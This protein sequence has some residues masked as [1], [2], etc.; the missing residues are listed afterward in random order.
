MVAQEVEALLNKV[1]ELHW[2]Y[3]QGLVAV[4][5]VL[6]L[7]LQSWDG[8]CFKSQ[9]YKL[10]EWFAFKSVEGNTVLHIRVHPSKTIFSNRHFG[11][12]QVYTSFLNP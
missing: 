5:S 3:Q 8:H 9:I 1:I 4:S 7:F 6:S 2:M 10:I 11:I 12:T